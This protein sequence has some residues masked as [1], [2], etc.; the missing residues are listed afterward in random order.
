MP[1]EAV[2]FKPGEKFSF[3][4][5]KLEH[6]KSSLKQSMD[7]ARAVVEG[8]FIEQG[9]DIMSDYKGIISEKKYLDVIDKIGGVTNTSGLARMTADLNNLK[10]YRTVESGFKET[11]YDK[12]IK[13][14]TITIRN[15]S[16]LVINFSI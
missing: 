3:E 8:R 6:L 10:N 11:L 2:Y 14:A 9:R 7:A 16:R 12:I 13:E 5:L 4:K 15:R 1:I